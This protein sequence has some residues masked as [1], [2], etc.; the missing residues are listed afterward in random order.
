MIYFD[1]AA[2][3]GFKPDI[4]K[5]NT[6]KAINES[7]VNLGRSLSNS[8]LQAEETVYM[9]RKL[10]SKNLN[11]GHI[12][13]LIFTKNC[14]E[15]LNC[16]IFGAKLNGSEIVTT[17]TEHNSV[18]RPLYRLSEH[19]N[20][21]I[22][23][24]KPD[25][26]GGV[27]AREVINLVNEKTAFVIMNAVSN[28]TGIK[29]QYEEVGRMLHG[30]VPFFVD[31]AQ[32]G[33]QEFDMKRDGI[34]ALA[35][36]GHKG[37]YA[38][39]GIGVLAINS[40]FDLTPILYGGSG[41]ETFEKL[42]SCYPELFEAGTQNYPSIVSLYYGAK[43]AFENREYH[44]NRIKN[45][46]NRLIGGLLNIDKV[47]LY[48]LPNIYGIVSFEVLNIPS[49][50]VSEVL[51]KNYGISVRGGFHC[52]PLMH[53]HLGTCENGLVRIS[54]SPYNTENEIDYFLQI[55]PEVISLCFES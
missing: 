26:H 53:T 20:L 44:N 31:G 42:P 36:A 28:V 45:L 35:F 27:N 23:Y 16:I 50:L 22:R 9:C 7:A 11:N 47:K 12:G 40:N 29:N 34:S 39:Q 55:L 13:R 38:M 37:L 25:E 8:A 3:G 2:T 21:T 48:S 30:K 1:N 6:I 5:Q 43:F 17:V 10:L 54:L 51:S 4:V 46:V 15:A 33:G 52:A 24:A 32:A 18:L 49:A 14:T 19:N 41:T